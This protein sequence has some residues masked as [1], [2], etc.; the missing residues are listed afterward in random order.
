VGQALSARTVRRRIIDGT[1]WAIVGALLVLTAIVL[2]HRVTWYLS[3]DQFGYLTFA[4][5]LGHG[6]V[7]HSWAPA[8]ALADV[9]PIRTDVLAQ[10]YIADHGRIYCRY[11]PGFPLLLA[12]WM[13]AFGPAAAHDLNPV[14]FV[15]L[16]A[17]VIA[18]E[19]RLSRSPWR[20]VFAAF[21]IAML[22][23]MLHLWGLTL[24]RDM[25]A[26]LSAFAGLFLLLPR[27]GA[28]LSGARAACA[29]VLLG[30]A[31]SIRPDQ[32]LYLLPALVLWSGHWRRSRAPASLLRGAL[33]GGIVGMLPLLIYNGL[34]TGNP[35]RLTQAMEL[36]GYGEVSDPPVLPPS[37]A[38]EAPRVQHPSPVWRGG[39]LVQVNGGG[40]ALRNL[41]GTFAGHLAFLVDAYGPTFL[42]LAGLGAALAFVQRPLLFFIAVPYVLSA[43]LFYS[44]WTRPDSRYLIG[45]H[46]FL[47]LLI[48]EGA[49]GPFAL[50]RRVARG[51]RG[52]RLLAAGFG[53]AACLAVAAARDH[54]PVRESALR[55]LSSLVP[56]LLAT[57]AAAAIVWPRRRVVGAV[58]MTVGLAVSGVGL[59]RAVAGLDRRAPFQQAEMEAARA[60]VRA[61][62][63]PGA[64]VITMEELGRPAENIEYYSGVANALYLTDLTRWRLSPIEAVTRFRGAGKPVYLLFAAETRETLAVLGALR[65]R[66]PVDL[67][68]DV[69]RD[70][71][72]THFVSG[73]AQAG[74]RV[75]WYRV[76]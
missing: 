47:I 71:A 25:A 59:S 46:L 36:G 41:P 10:T 18:F 26:H 24:T 32:V 76:Q 39:T 58:G 3:V 27:R 43:L 49:F 29:G 63:E 67:L 52:A 65:E 28:A 15:S 60:N 34:A 74:I 11:A 40:F 69:P 14:L 68:A 45:V 72:L 50:I 73:P 55:L 42:G 12:G 2:V 35:L 62:V 33:V 61:L 37:D 16:L 64:V 9:L 5:D 38:T 30:Y 56:A 19:R 4:T 31:V 70:E 6:R 66:W 44:C 7:F 13:A 75:Q 57:G 20:A 23:T 21:L 54:L 48:A 17:V 1:W 8:A 53:V 51:P 22:P